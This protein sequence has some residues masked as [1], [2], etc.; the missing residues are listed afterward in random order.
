MAPTSVSANGRT[1]RTNSGTPGTPGSSVEAKKSK[2]GPQHLNFTSDQSDESD[3][4]DM[5]QTLSD[6]IQEKC[7]KSL[8]QLIKK[9]PKEQK[10]SMKMMSEMFQLMMP[11]LV[12]TCVTIIK[13]TVQEAFTKAQPYSNLDAKADTNAV[14]FKTDQLEQKS[15]NKNVRV[16]GID[17]KVKT[18]TDGK[19]VFDEED[20]DN[21][22]DC[23]IN[24]GAHMDIPIKRDDIDEIYRCGKKEDPKKKRQ[25][26]V[27]FARVSVRNK[28]CNN[29]KKLKE[30]EIKVY[31]NDDLT[32]AKLFMLKEIKKNPSV[33]SCFSRDGRI[34]VYLK[35]ATKPIAVESPDDLYEV[36]LEE[37]AF[38]EAIKIMKRT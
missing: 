4:D 7:K 14:L 38:D 18:D 36:G 21:L 16:A 19:V 37:S 13:S 2:N 28:L 27:T 31:I 15:R 12:D 8:P 10:E 11:L 34:L 25:I 24:L 9:A 29:K 30:K 20:E 33:K 5:L 23:I 26:H 22:K 6:D 17:E 1:K 3:E 35:D 32:P